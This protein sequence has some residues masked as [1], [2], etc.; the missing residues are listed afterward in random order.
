VVQI[1]IQI[2]V[3]FEFVPRTLS[4][5]IWWILGCSI[6]SGNCHTLGIV[7]HLISCSIHIVYDHLTQDLPT[8]SVRVRLGTKNI[9]FHDPFIYPLWSF[10]VYYLWS[11]YSYSGVVWLIHL[12]DVTPS[13][14][15]RDGTVSDVVKVKGEDPATPGPLT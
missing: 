10:F 11:F 1:E 3:S 13:D 2:L 7:S 6:V 4:F 12:C 14:V 5:W 9:I 15:W 8:I